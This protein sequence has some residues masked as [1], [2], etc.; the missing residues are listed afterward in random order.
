M[1]RTVVPILTGI[2][3]VIMGLALCNC[4]T[5]GHSTN[6]GPYVPWDQPTPY[7]DRINVTITEDPSHGF[8]VTWRT[9]TSV[10]KAVAEIAIATPAPRFFRTGTQVSARTEYFD[11]SIIE[12]ESVQANYHSVTFN[13]LETDTIYAYRV[14]DG[15]HWSEWF[16]VRTA[17]EKPEPFSFIYFGDAQN[18]LQQLWSRVIRAAYAKSPDARFVVHAGD[19]V[20]RGHYNA[21]WGEWFYSGSFI[22]S[23]LP[24]VPAPGNHEYRRYTNKKNEQDIG[25][26]AV[27]WKPQFTL[28]ENGVEGLEETN[29]YV[30]FQGVRIIVLNSNEKVE[31]QA[32]WLDEVLAD[33]QNKWT[34]VTFHHPI[35]SS[36]KRRDNQDLRAAWKPMFDKYQVDL[37]MQGHDHTYA[38]GHTVNVP[39]GVN[40]REPLASTVYVNSVSG[41]KMYKLKEGKWDQYP[42]V[43]ME[44]S[45][46]NTQLFQVIH[47]NNDTLQ[48]RAYTAIG[49]VYD[50]FDLIKQADGPNRFIE[51]TPLPEIR[52]HQN[53]IPYKIN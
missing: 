49:D 23:M 26:L 53:T 43:D 36:S 50:G 4:A 18:D 47:V 21:Q 1:N 41:R 5:I 14:G 17:S 25:H 48:F 30:D 20:N 2:L 27:H 19:L 8:S 46:E 40:L 10:D 11:G 34:V 3:F 16:H 13:N 39:T 51:I 6:E 7:P 45:A 29:Y 37:V 22:H 52:T 28:P 42:D 38:R 9:N 44:R 35:F 33:N 31:E 12:G 15:S 24:V 32:Q